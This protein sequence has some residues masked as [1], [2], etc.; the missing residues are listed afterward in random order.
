MSAGAI[1]Q[2]FIL[3][4]DVTLTSASGRFI[5]AIQSFM[6]NPCEI[7][8]TATTTDLSSTTETSA[9]VYTSTYEVSYLETITISM[10]DPTTSSTLTVN[11]LRLPQ[12]YDL[13]RNPDRCQR[14]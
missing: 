6:T 4:G 10:P 7:T 12:R 13:D 11:S 14:E 2:Y 9:V 8:A 5:G 1:G 3:N